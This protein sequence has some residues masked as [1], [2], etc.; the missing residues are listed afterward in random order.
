M[1]KK[2]NGKLEIIRFSSGMIPN[3]NNQNLHDI[4]LF[5]KYLWLQKVYYLTIGGFAYSFYTGLRST[6]DCDIFV[7]RV[8]ENSRKIIDILK[9]LDVKNKDLSV[10]S[11]KE[12]EGFLRIETPQMKLDIIN[13]IDGI[14]FKSAWERRQI[15]K[16]EDIEI[17]FI[18]LE[19]LILNKKSTGK[20]RD[21]ND[22][23]FLEKRMNQ[24]L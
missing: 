17:I 14:E 6:K 5:F 22:V 3:S 20:D 16:Y 13:F 8:E 11:L 19:D 23:Q 21:F 12:E 2:N 10:A 7:P 9:Q 15:E 24:P 4:R 1:K 18:S